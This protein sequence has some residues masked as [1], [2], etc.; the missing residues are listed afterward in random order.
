[1]SDMRVKT[2]VLGAVS[3][4][5]YLVYN[6]GT[7]KA[8]IV[9]PAD[10]AQFILNKCNELGITPEAI[11]LTHGHFDHI[12][13]VSAVREHYHA[14]VYI[15][16]ADA[17]MLSDPEKNMSAMMG[18]L[19]VQ[20]APAEQQMKNVEKLHLAGMEIVVLSTPGHSPG[21]VCYLSGDYLFS[22]DT[23]FNLSAGRTDFPGGSMENLNAS[24]ELLKKIEKDY[25]VH[26]G[27]EGSTS[28][29]FEKDNNPF[30]GNA[31]WSF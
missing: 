2:C 12:A 26:P 22:G 7:K 18:G 10:N 16:A 28:L 1:M 11:L 23:L 14:P 9:D 13:G 8:V 31:E 17:P 21:S 25:I 27:H 20:T 3:T 29:Q 15:H 30:M 6:E 19:R 24:M 4:N 5:C